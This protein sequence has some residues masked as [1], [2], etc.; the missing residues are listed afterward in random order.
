MIHP[1]IQTGYNAIR[2][3]LGTVIAIVIEQ[4][5]DIAQPRSSAIKRN[6]FEV[7]SFLIQSKVGLNKSII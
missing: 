6:L 5:I 4:P 2:G 1:H 3:G 7:K